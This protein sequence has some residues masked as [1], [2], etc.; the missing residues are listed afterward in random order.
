MYGQEAVMPLEYIVPSLRVVAFID[1]VN[2]DAIQDILA[3][4]ME[5]DED[6]FLA[7]CHQQVQKNR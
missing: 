1:V 6:R 2:P 3:V 5:L 7:D 4:I